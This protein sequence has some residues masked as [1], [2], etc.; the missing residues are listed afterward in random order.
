MAAQEAAT[1]AARSRPTIVMRLNIGAKAR[2][3]IGVIRFFRNAPVQ[4]VQHF[5]RQFR[6]FPR[7][8]VDVF[9]TTLGEFGGEVIFRGYVGERL[10]EW[11]SFAPARP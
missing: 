11:K 6:D 3:Q 9:Q 8:I 5:H 10:G 4:P 2:L 7:S 1:D